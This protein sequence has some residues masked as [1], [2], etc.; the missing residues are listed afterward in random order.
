MPS[1]PILVVDDHPLNLKLASLLLTV[2]GHEVRTAIDAAAAL[3]ILESFMPRLILMDVQMPR[4]DGLEL[5]RLLKANP[6]RSKIIIVA[7]TSYAMK[8][9]EEKF[10]AAGCDG[11]LAKPI[12]TRTFAAQVQSFLT[13]SE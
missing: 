8:G 2:E 10:R 3:N 5:T 12:N 7:M 11:Y 6:V 9:D 13:E 4:M 1:T